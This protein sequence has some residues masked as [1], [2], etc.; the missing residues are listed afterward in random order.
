MPAIVDAHVVEQGDEHV[1][2]GYICM[3]GIC[4]ANDKNS[5]CGKEQWWAFALLSCLQE[6]RNAFII[7][8]TAAAGAGT[9]QQRSSSAFYALRGLCRSLLSVV[10][11]CFFT[12]QRDRLKVEQPC[13]SRSYSFIHSSEG[14]QKREKVSGGRSSGHERC[15]QELVEAAAARQSASTQ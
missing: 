3:V 4:R 1:R 10:H 15:R 2:R 12:L 9:W 13:V 7:Q 14:Q 8:S 11:L 5:P 6:T